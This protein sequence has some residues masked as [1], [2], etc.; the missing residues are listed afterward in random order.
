MKDFQPVV[1]TLQAALLRRMGD[2]VDLIFQYGS[3][4]KGTAHEYSDVDIS[5]V[6]IHATTWNAITVMVDDTLF[7]LY[8]IHWARL[9]QMAAYSDVSATVLLSSRIAYQRTDGAAERF[10]GLSAQLR[11]LL[12][13]DARPEM[14]R[15]ALE[16][17]QGAG[18]DTYLLREQAAND[19]QTGCLKQAHAILRTVLHCL[20]V[21]NQQCIDTRKLA[22]VLAL[23][24]LPVDFAATVERVVAAMEPQDVVAAV[25]TLLRTTRDLLLTEQRQCLGAAATYPDVFAAAYPELKRDLQ[26]IMQACERQDMFALKGAVLS[27]QHEMARGVA[28]VAT[29]FVSTGFNGLA[30]YDQDLTA[31]GFP[32]LTPLLVAGDFAALH[33]QTLLFDQR[34]R[35]FLAERAVKLNNFATLAELQQFLNGDMQG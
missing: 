13:P 10:R 3:H 11:D 15:R 28:Q 19:H 5:W 4:L 30:D 27:L 2:E 16:I 1:D 17:F 34:L 6:P 7:D 29:G 25:E 33:R 8:P 31:L 24:K 12:Q 20:A 14:V 9:E 26:A 21:C 32:A 23:P 18:Y 35:E 22:Q